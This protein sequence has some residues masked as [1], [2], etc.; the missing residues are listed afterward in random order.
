MVKGRTTLDRLL[1][2]SSIYL[3]YTILWHHFSKMYPK[4]ICLGL[5][6][7]LNSAPSLI[8]SI[9]YL[10]EC[11]SYT[12]KFWHIHHAFHPLFLGLLYWLMTPTSTQLFT[13]DVVSTS[14]L[15]NILHFTFSM[16]L[17]SVFIFFVYYCLVHFIFFGPNS[18]PCDLIIPSYTL[19]YWPLS[20]LTFDH[21]TTRLKVF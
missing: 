7:L 4:F 16:H 6:L 20:K 14:S 2:Y 13:F 21:G 18:F 12:L 15:P 17:M 8:T 19:L 11:I 1:G 3:F 10:Y 9:R 5:T